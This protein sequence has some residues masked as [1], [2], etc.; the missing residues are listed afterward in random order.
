MKPS[1]LQKILPSRSQAFIVSIALSVHGLILML[2]LSEDPKPQ[3]PSSE[4][5]R[6][7]RLPTT[8]S[9]PPSPKSVKPSPVPAKTPSVQPSLIPDVTPRST[10]PTPK[11]QLPDAS[12]KPVAQTTSFDDFPQYPTAQLGSCNLFQGTQDTASQQTQDG[13]PAV[14]Q[15]FE[16]ALLEKGYTAQAISS[17]PKAKVY[18]VVKGGTRKFLNLILCADQGTAIVLSNQP[19]DLSKLQ[20]ATTASQSEALFDNV[21]SQLKQ[22]GEPVILVS[23]ETYFEQ[24][25]AFYAKSAKDPNSYDSDRPLPGFDGNFVYRKETPEQLVSTFF[26]TRL[27]SFQLTKMTNYGNGQVYQ[28]KQGEF[29]RYL[30]FVPAKGS[31]GTLVLVWNRIPS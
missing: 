15:Y 10:A 17:D 27:T 11:P 14:A 16:Q 24:P 7:S 29:V 28:V 26:Q 4:T 2:P 30:N 8:T 1:Y 23:P 22:S 9:I 21:L 25:G 6:I 5:V 31:P 12:P 19:I 18:Q 13:Q 20:S 3:S